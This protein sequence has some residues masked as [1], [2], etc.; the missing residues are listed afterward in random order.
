MLLKQAGTTKADTN[1]LYEEITAADCGSLSA[2]L[3]KFRNSPIMAGKLKRKILNEFNCN[4]Q[5]KFLNEI[6]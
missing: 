4:Y 2:S 6:L 1:G 3:M 5:I